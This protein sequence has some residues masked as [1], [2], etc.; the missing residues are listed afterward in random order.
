M[1][2]WSVSKLPHLD[3]AN[4]KP[5]L[6]ESECEG[7]AFLQRLWQEYVEGTNCFAGQ[8]ESLYGV[9][10]QGLLIGIGGL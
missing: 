9:Y 3:L 5:L 2:N 1:T 7:F 4:L 6:Y 10:N 8:G